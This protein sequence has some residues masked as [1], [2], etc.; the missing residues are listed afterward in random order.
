MYDDT[1]NPVKRGKREWDSRGEND[2]T[3]PWNRQEG[4]DP[5]QKS[6]VSPHCH[7]FCDTHTRTHARTP[8]SPS[9]RLSPRFSWPQPAGVVLSW[10]TKN[11]G[12]WMYVSLIVWQPLLRL[13]RSHQ[14]IFLHTPL[15]PG[16]HPP[17]CACWI[18]RKTPS[19][20]YAT[21]FLKRG[22]GPNPAFWHPDFRRPVRLPPAGLPPSLLSIPSFPPP[23]QRVD[24]GP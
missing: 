21:G 8:Q 18:S 5:V 3:M 2:K 7:S 13:H 10:A 15:N 23:S 24:R 11:W 17:V 1:N 12:N 6:V 19:S 16:P 9:S 20:W 14:W 22:G 4:W